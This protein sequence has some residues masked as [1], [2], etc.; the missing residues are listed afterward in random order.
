[1]E[2]FRT[3]LIFNNEMDL[4]KYKILTVLKISNRKKWR[5]ILNVL[6]ILKKIILMDVTNRLD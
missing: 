4:N 5:M 2:Y 1:M 3:K 6:N